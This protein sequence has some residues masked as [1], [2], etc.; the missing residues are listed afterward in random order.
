MCFDVCM[1]VANTIHFRE[2]NEKERSL[3]KREVR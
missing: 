3:S 2:R 1:Y